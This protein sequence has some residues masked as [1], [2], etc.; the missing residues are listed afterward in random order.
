MD[1]KFVQ[2][3]ITSLASQRDHALNALAH[4]EAELKI[5]KDNNKP[6]GPLADKVK[7]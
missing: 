2:A 1:E 3:L 6:E 5:L 7:G 4:L